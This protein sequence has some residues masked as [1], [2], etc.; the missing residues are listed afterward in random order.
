ME[1]VTQETPIIPT[2]PPRRV[3]VVI[4]PITRPKGSSTYGIDPN[5]MDMTTNVI[6]PTSNSD[7]EAIIKMRAAIKE[8]NEA[9]VRSLP[10][11]PPP[12]EN[13]HIQVEEPPIPI[14]LPSQ[15]SISNFQQQQQNL[16]S[17]H[18]RNAT[19]INEEQ[20]LLFENYGID[21]THLMQPMT[22]EPK[23]TATP[24]LLQEFLDKFSEFTPISH[25]LDIP[26]DKQY[27]FMSAFRPD[28]ALFDINYIKE[29]DEKMTNMKLD[30]QDALSM[31]LNAAHVWNEIPY[32]RRQLL[33]NKP[34][35]MEVPM[36]HAINETIRHVEEG[37]IRF[38]TRICREAMVAIDAFM[39][40]AEIDEDERK[41]SAI[42]DSMDISVEETEQ[43]TREAFLQRNQ[44]IIEEQAR[45]Q[46]E[47]IRNLE[48]QRQ[49]AQRIKDEQFH[50]EMQRR[51]EERAHEAYVAEEAR[52]IER[53]NDPNHRVKVKPT[54]YGESERKISNYFN[55][56]ELQRQKRPTLE[57]HMDRTIDGATFRFHTDSSQEALARR[58]D[59][60]NLL[61]NESILRNVRNPRVG[62][63]L[64][65]QD[66]EVYTG[67]FKPGEVDDDL[68][69]GIVA[70]FLGIIYKD[71]LSDETKKA[72]DTHSQWTL[73]YLSDLRVGDDSFEVKR[74][75]R[76]HY[77]Y[78]GP[79]AKDEMV[80][81]MVGLC[82]PFQITEDVPHKIVTNVRYK[83]QAYEKV[84]RAL[85]M[86]YREEMHQETFTN[87]YAAQVQQLRRRER[88][89]EGID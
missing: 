7:F 10:A 70:M 89:A 33:L 77:D 46:Q 64:F 28:S 81:T 34:E 73:H 83:K 6:H 52:K 22:V 68:T 57:V 12:A 40:S 37:T 26:V 47:E 65:A 75:L 41:P 35:N 59:K 36:D 66:D 24:E 15:E 48:A 85:C 20:Q 78:G 2:Q 1:E 23:P 11:E 72:L 62:A 67:G 5:E 4:Q 79:N 50:Q 13:M 56:Q 31:T 69:I 54:R 25:I 38:D 44:A 19:A 45:L 43:R 84:L 74:R 60:F 82:K 53:Y 55:E 29:N 51:N 30:T 16:A 58:V 88:E 21:T 76:T 63:T 42:D 8:R 27:L 61:M 87:E 86:I 18:S 71:E 3:P 32:H 80:G 17:V 9:F 14:H 49:E 39:M